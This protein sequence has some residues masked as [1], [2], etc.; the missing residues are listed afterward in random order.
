MT[1]EVS[2]SSCKAKVVI[3]VKVVQICVDHLMTEHIVILTESERDICRL[4]ALIDSNFGVCLFQYYYVA[5]SQC[6]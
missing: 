6:L 4:H 5:Y 2:F 3:S 1:S